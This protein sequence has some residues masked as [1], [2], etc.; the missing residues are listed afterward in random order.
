MK[1]Q[2]LK[3]VLFY[4]FLSML[5]VACSEADEQTVYVSKGFWE[6]AQNAASKGLNY[7]GDVYT[8][9]KNEMDNNPA[10]F[11][12]YQKSFDESYN[13]AANILETCAKR[14]DE[15]EAKIE[16]ATDVDFESVQ[17]VVNGYKPDAVVE[18]NIGTCGYIDLGLP[19]GTLWATA[20]LGIQQMSKV[21]NNFS[22]YFNLQKPVRPESP[23]L[24]EAINIREY[25]VRKSA[26]EIEGG[27]VEIPYKEFVATLE[28]VNYEAPSV[29]NLDKLIWAIKDELLDNIENKAI[30][31][32][33]HQ[34]FD[35]ERRDAVKYVEEF[36]K[37]F[38]RYNFD[39][40]T[41]DFSYLLDLGTPYSWG[42][43]FVM[44]DKSGSTTF[45]ASEDWVTV[46]LG[47]NWSTPTKEQVE[48]LLQ[49]CEL[50][51][52]SNDNFAKGGSITYESNNQLSTGKIQGYEL[53]SKFNG[54]TLFIPGDYYYMINERV[55]AGKYY[56]LQKKIITV[57]DRNPKF[58]I[59][60]VYKSK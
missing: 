42:T 39:I 15:A 22:E 33:D 37:A 47:S 3:K 7:N 21:G 48:E 16:A 43:N 8:F 26:E 54:K 17:K 24:P 27:C 19:S 53:K 4:V 36:N 41:H 6:R 44:D 56:V 1:K 45:S 32:R 55:D 51:N 31:F 50:T 52:V 23:K 20:N 28:K 46:L 35:Y 18:T 9:I 29:E 59:R 13:N 11:D 34:V 38:N 12:A 10:V 49:Y 60:P 25:I 14:L 57:Q 40:L 2:L 58:R 5:F 30:N